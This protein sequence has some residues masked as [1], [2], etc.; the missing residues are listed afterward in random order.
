MP[1]SLF[2]ENFRIE[3]TR[4]Q[5][6]DYSRA[7]WYFVT[8]CTRDHVH[9]FGEVVNGEMQLSPIGEIV[10]E[11]WQKTPQVRSKVELDTWTVMPNHLHGI[12]VITHQI[13]KPDAVEISQR[14]DAPEG[15][16]DPAGRLYVVPTGNALTC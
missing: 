16:D 2:K 14:A 7:G 1:T 15:R 6:W 4:L 10:T 5:G 11:E 8:I 12:V 9:F 13:S 3:S